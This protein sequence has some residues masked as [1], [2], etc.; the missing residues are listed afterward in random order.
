VVAARLRLFDLAQRAYGEALDLDSAIG[1]AQRDVGVVRLERRRWALSLE[2]LADAAM[3]VPD[4]DGPPAPVTP[5]PAVTPPRGPVLDRSGVIAGLFRA[6]VLYAS[7]GLLIAAVLAAVMTA[8]SSGV[9]RTWGG[10]IGVVV[11]VAFLVWLSRLLPVSLGDAL[12]EVRSSP[13]LVAAFYAVA[14]APV[15]LVAFAVLGGVVP[16]IVAMVLA[17]FA[18]L[19]VLTQRSA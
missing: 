9:A 19:A 7:N 16:L 8:V 18:E 13:R 6:A 10:V 15:G 11:L 17:A 5:P 2:D 1:D 4:P 12:R 14:L 3:P